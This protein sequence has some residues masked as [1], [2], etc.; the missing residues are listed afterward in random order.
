MDMMYII[1]RMHHVEFIKSTKH[2]HIGRGNE[3]L[4]M[5]YNGYSKAELY[6]CRHI[7]LWVDESDHLVLPLE[8]ASRGR[9]CLILSIV[10]T[11]VEVDLPD[12]N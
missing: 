9:Q 1:T 3:R 11:G 5:Y 6:G 4:E 7:N 2:P 8:K 12:M 10:E